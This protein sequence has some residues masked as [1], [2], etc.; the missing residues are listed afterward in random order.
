MILTPTMKTP[1]QSPHHPINQQYFPA[2][3]IT[4]EQTLL[5]DYKGKLQVDQIKQEY[6]TKTQ[7]Y[8]KK[9][10]D[11]LSMLVVAIKNKV[12]VPTKAEIE[13]YDYH[14][15]VCLQQHIGNHYQ[16]VHYCYQSQIILM[17]INRQQQHQKYS[18]V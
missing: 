9:E 8:S 6:K 17:E 10:E 11:L 12:G 18:L 5:V 13:K 1:F 14:S 7:D 15:M 4:K 2:L 16:K 3:E